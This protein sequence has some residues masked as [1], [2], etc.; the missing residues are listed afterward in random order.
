MD[1]QSKQ[2][3]RDYWHDRSHTKQELA[4]F[5]AALNPPVVLSPAATTD[6]MVDECLAHVAT[7]G[8]L[9]TFDEDRAVWVQGTSFVSTTHEPSPQ[10]EH[11]R[12]SETPSQEA[13]GPAVNQGRLAAALD[14]LEALHMLPPRHQNQITEGMEH[15]AAE[16]SRLVNEARAAARLSSPNTG[17]A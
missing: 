6:A 13:S 15:R 4:D 7:H 9:L 10:Y 2:A 16:T 11:P 14:A 17:A 3:F 5:G 8:I 1:E 12:P